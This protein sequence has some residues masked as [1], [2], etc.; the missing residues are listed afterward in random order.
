VYV[1]LDTC[2]MSSEFHGSGGPE[3]SVSTGILNLS[4][5][6]NTE[7]DT[8]KVTD[9]WSVDDPTASFL[10]TLYIKV[11]IQ[12]ASL[13]SFDGNWYDSVECAY[14]C[15]I[16]CESGDIIFRVLVICS[17]K[18]AFTSNITKRRSNIDSVRV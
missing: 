11:C 9:I 18:V 14:N 17:G 6:C 13:C 8:R 2:G 5:W 12:V 1:Y 10:Y 15:I 4:N 3:E 16:E 7:Y